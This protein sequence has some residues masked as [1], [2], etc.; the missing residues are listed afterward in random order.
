[1]RLKNWF[2]GLFDQKKDAQERMLILFVVVSM[3]ALFVITVVGALIGE[4]LADLM[5]LG[6]AFI[7]FGALAYMAFHFDRVQLCAIIVASLLIFVVMPLTFI[8][9][10]GIYG[11]SPIWFI[12][13]GVFICMVVIGKWRIILTA[14]NIVAIMVCYY[15]QYFYP[16]LISGH[17]KEMMFQ[18]SL[19]SV[20]LVCL[21]VCFLVAFEVRI[22]Q[23]Q[24][25][26][27]EEQ[28]KEIDNQNKAQNTFFSSMSHE[29]RTPINTIIGL[30]E[31][32]LREDISEEVAEDANNVRSASKI[33]LH[34][35]NDILDMSKIES[36]KMM[37]TPEI[38]NMGDLI[39][40]IV[41]MFWMRAKEKG[42]AFHVDVDPKLPM[43][44]IGDD[45]R[46]K[47]ILI[48]LLNNA[49]K[50]TVEGSIV[51]SIQFRREAEKKGTV[52]FTVTDTGIGIKKESI[53]HLFNAFR[54]VNETENRYIEGTGLGLSIVKQLVELMGGSIS[55][56]SVY[57]K[58][59]TFIVDIPQDVVGDGVMKGKDYNPELRSISTHRSDY[60]QKFDA[61]EARVLV[62]DDN[63][64]N[65]L[66]VTKILRDTHM[67]ID[68]AMSGQ[69]ALNKTLSKEY[70]MI[71]MDHL[72]PE[73]DGIECL[74]RIKTQV[75]GMCR[76]SKVVA[77]TA[78]A[79][80]DNKAL[81]A[82]EGFDGY[83]VKPTSG[84]ALEN[85]CMRLL[86]KDIVHAIYSDDKIVEESMSWMQ[87]HERKEEIIIS[88][89][90]VADISPEMIQRLGIAIIPHKISTK[91][92]L[93]TDG[94]EIEAQGLISYMEDDDNIVKNVAPSVE[95]YEA[96]F[97]GLLTRAHNILHISISADVN[98]SG[99]PMAVSASEVFDNVTVVDSR[100]LSSGQGLMVL[101]AC[102]MAK[103]GMSAEVIKKTLEKKYK[104][105]S[106]SFV[107][108][109]LKYMARAG[110]VDNWIYVV[111]KAILMRPVLRM[112]KGKI[113]VGRIFFGSQKNSWKKYIDSELRFSQNI[114]KGL[115]YVTY[116]GMS[117]K[118]LDYIHQEI[119][120]LVDFEQIIFQKASPV[121]ALNCGPGTFGLLYK[122][123]NRIE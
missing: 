5:T 64:S 44:L 70:H 118:D 99:C 23:E 79:G 39:S 28:R 116:V 40:E 3:S 17:D 76:H 96:F 50:Y 65:L 8:T 31:M 101:E 63:A 48:N 30:N 92:G 2:M 97:A 62:V 61:P 123:T 98:D 83:L 36:G 109:S 1:M 68:T 14:A 57:T 113:T 43:E 75:G 88:T 51:L 45:V 72:M 53:P 12:F 67:Q 38:Y 20:I 122:K 18:D 89:D 11:G 27:S 55:V 58:G 42:L 47:Q 117:Q 33:L 54:R 93:F 81:Y 95:E 119:T 60:R 111:S 35:I 71:F 15:V 103:E 69:E 104:S 26:R 25:R 37:L 120:R 74:H 114:D 34:L 59:S 4:S 100:H 108:S 46:L 91:D 9:G 121:I 24:Y 85:E 52:T 107:V 86:P 49:I 77:L 80:A 78:N 94:K 32:I 7:V 73:M 10:G 90:S 29:I 22:L 105:F 82:S 21:L 84:E 41:G 115:L 16:D 112:K 6:A 106:T 87:E 102:R 66:V 19:V 110:Q 13:C 56:N